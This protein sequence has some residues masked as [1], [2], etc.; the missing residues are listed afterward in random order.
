MHCDMQPDIRLKRAYDTPSSSD[1]ARVLVDGIW[2]RGVSKDDLRIRKW[3]RSVAPS[4]TLRQWFAHDP[5]KWKAFRQRYLVELHDH[6]A[7]L[8]ELVE[9]ASTGRLTLVYGARD[10]EHNQAVVLRELIERQ[11][12]QHIA[13]R[14]H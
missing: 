12:R 5:G 14:R 2:P 11:L 13:G 9:L 10:R 1:G 3:M 4:K 6:V 8:E 7:E